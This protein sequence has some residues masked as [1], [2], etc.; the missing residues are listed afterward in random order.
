MFYIAFN[1]DGS[2]EALADAD[3]T[4]ED[5]ERMADPAFRTAAEIEAER[6][7]QRR[8]SLRELRERSLTKALEAARAGARGEITTRSAWRRHPYPLDGEV[9]E[10]RHRDPMR[11]ETVTEMA[12]WN[13][14]R[15]VYETEKRAI[16][17]EDIDGWK[18]V[19]LA[20]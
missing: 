18:V 9:V 14:D 5:R 20:R 10:I 6:E 11:G 8:E 1:A 7:Q 4:A 15:S 13:D 2:F 12:R 3:L 19:R 16:H 17:C